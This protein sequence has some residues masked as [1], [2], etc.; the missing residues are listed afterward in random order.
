M[1]YAI[2]PILKLENE[3]LIGQLAQV[4]SLSTTISTFSSKR[5]IG[6]EKKKNP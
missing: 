1:D 3:N 5:G 4:I 2:C 6:F